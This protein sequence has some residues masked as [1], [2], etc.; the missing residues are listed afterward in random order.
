MHVTGLLIDLDYAQAFNR[1][2]MSA[3]QKLQGTDLVEDKRQLQTREQKV[4]RQDSAAQW[5]V[6]NS[7]PAC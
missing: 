1:E 3:L 2:T 7:L 6:V 4:T 5:T